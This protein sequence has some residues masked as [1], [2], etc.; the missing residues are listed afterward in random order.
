MELSA[1]VALKQTYAAA[2]LY[3]HSG[4][5]GCTMLELQVAAYWN[6]KYQHADTA[7]VTMLIPGESAWWYEGSQHADSLRRSL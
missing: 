4:T 3:Q 7:G 2:E 1:F 5:A 6:F